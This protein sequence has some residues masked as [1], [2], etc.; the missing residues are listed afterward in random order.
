MEKVYITLI[1]INVPRGGDFYVA[2]KS[3]KISS[4]EEVRKL[5]IR[6]GCNKEE[7]L[8]RARMI[9]SNAKIVGG[10]ILARNENIEIGGVYKPSKEDELPVDEFMNFFEEKVSEFKESVKNEFKRKGGK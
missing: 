3:E 4:I 2:L 10:I 1:R 6:E 7:I 9:D 5:G 8:E